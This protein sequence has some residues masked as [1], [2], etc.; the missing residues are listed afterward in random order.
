MKIW[1]RNFKNFSLLLALVLSFTISSINVAFA[2]E[3][4][5]IVVGEV[6][7]NDDGQEEMVVRTL[8][9]VLL[10]QNLPEFFQIAPSAS[11]GYSKGERKTTKVFSCRIVQTG[12]IIYNCL[13]T[14]TMERE[15]FSGRH[16]HMGGEIAY[17]LSTVGKWEPSSAPTGP[18]GS[19]GTLTTTYTAAEA[20]GTINLKITAIDQDNGTFIPDFNAS[21]RVW[22]N[23]LVP[24]ID[25][26][27]YD[28]VGGTPEHTDGWNTTVD[29][30]NK[31]ISIA[32]K[33]S[34]VYP[35]PSDPDAPRIIQYNDMSLVW[36]GL[37]D[38][39][40]LKSSG[41]CGG[42][43]GAGNPHDPWKLSPHKSHRNGISVD[44][45]IITLDKQH[46]ALMKKILKG[47]KVNIWPNSDHWHL[48][49][50]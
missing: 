9:E 20:S 27:N 42:S 22:V 8:Q 28:L 29:F 46:R 30:R 16:I 12:A 35:P 13:L 36:G 24:V 15:P 41:A 11:H 48:Y 6:V 2:Q 1:R 19:P 23:N 45:R 44:L 47:E 5:E 38:I 25:G 49:P 3:V 43:S 10:T 50:K 26:I 39:C 7:T 31:L 37:F 40:Y 33:F 34:M 21:I 18:L 14:L 32:N 17:P 4:G